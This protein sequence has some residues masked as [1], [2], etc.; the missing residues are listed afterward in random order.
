MVHTIEHLAPWLALE[1]CQQVYHCLAPNG[2]FILEQP[3]ILYAAQVLLGL[4]L[5]P[6][7]EF[8]G[9]YSMAAFYGDPSHKDEY[10]L[11]RWGYHPS[12]LRA[13][14]QEAGFGNNRIADCP[15]IYHRP[16]RDFRIEARK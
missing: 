15:A 13:L 16:I 6:V 12:S 14:L 10:M 11:H 9:Q 3:N 7:E 4:I 2:V 1:L 5:A 8:P